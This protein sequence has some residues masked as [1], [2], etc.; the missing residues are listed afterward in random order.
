MTR[1]THLEANHSAG[2][3]CQRG[4]IGG[5]LH[6]EHITYPFTEFADLPAEQQC[7]K[8]R[9]SKRFSFLLRSAEKAAA[10]ALA[11]WEP[12]ADPDAWKAQDDALLA[13]HRARRI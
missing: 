8:C 6:G 4:H 7:A 5:R 10:A 2:P 11:A 1:K 13:T 9:G 12:V 3:V